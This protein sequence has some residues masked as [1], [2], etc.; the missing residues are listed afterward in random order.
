[1][2][3]SYWSAPTALPDVPTHLLSEQAPA[4]ISPDSLI[5]NLL[6]PPPTR[7]LSAQ[8]RRGRSANQPHPDDP[9]SEEYLCVFCSYDLFYGTT[10]A[11]RK[12]IEKRKKMLARRRRAKE[13]ASGVANG[14]GTAKTTKKAKGA[15]KKAN[16]RS[17]GV[18]DDGVDD[19]DYR[20]EGNSTGVQ[21][22]EEDEEWDCDETGEDGKCR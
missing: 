8:P 14:T 19:D 11:K 16:M 5:A 9:P 12:V 4:P 21:P 13:R 3:D 1:M 7:F 10:D 22:E 17:R 15:G 2:A 18:G 6:F 20:P